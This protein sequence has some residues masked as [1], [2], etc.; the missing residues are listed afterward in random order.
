MAPHGGTIGFM[1][2]FKP[3]KKKGDRR[4]TPK[5]GLP[6]LILILLGMGLVMLFL[7]LVMR[8]SAPVS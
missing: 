8:S 3:A 7:Y 2:H 5:P 1:P 6:C 4:A